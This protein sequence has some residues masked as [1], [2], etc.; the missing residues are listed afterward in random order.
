MGSWGVETLGDFLEWLQLEQG[1]Q[2][3]WGS[4]SHLLRDV[5]VS[6]VFPAIVT[7]YPHN[8]TETLHISPFSRRGL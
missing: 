2:R 3:G 8:G 7:C 6:D 5:S 1:W 4:S